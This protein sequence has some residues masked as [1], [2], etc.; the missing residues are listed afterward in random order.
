MADT[1][2]TFS[3]ECSDAAVTVTLTMESCTLM[4]GMGSLLSLDSW[5]SLPQTQQ[6]P[7]RIHIT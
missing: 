2:L 4:A 3:S 7:H 1:A 5:Y 6:R